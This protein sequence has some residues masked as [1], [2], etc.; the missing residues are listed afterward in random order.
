L[1]TRHYFTIQSIVKYRN[2]PNPNK[3][4]CCCGSFIVGLI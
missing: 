3:I 4:A 2:S 1:A